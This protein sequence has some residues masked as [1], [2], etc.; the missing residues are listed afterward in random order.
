LTES[1]GPQLPRSL[2]LR[3]PLLRPL[4]PRESADECAARLGI[5]LE[6]AQ[7]FAASDVIDLH[8]DSF[9]WRRIFGYRLDTRHGQGLFSAR[10]YSQVDFPRLRQVGI[11]G[12]TWVITT[13]PLRTTRGRALALAKNL[14]AIEGEL[15][16][17]PSD[18]R[19]VSTY[20]EYRSA[21]DNGLHA[22]FVGI[23]GGNA[24]TPDFAPLEAL[25][26]RRLLR[27]TLTHLTS[28][29]LGETSAPLGSA[30]GLGARGPE[31]VHLLNQKRIFVDLAH[32]N[33]LGFFEA[34]EA[35]DTS[36]P[37]IVTHT[38]V[39]AVHKH[40]RNLDDEQIRAIADRG[41]TLGIMYHT[42]F[43]DRTWGRASLD[44]VCAHIEHV[45]A[46]V[47]D[48]FVSLG[49]D[50]DGAIVTPKD[51][52]TCLEL[53]RLIQALLDRRWSP[54]SIQKLLGGNFL[55]VLRE[56]RGSE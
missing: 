1:P 5:S 41:G 30:R 48:D 44:V 6:A 37:P 35:H 34:L 19:R 46:K 10:F 20:A 13:N 7:L 24:I 33:R 39:S 2:L 55:R 43:L 53:P 9:I 14:A 8:V 28:S 26:A 52:P 32:I 38:G 22:A 56:L 40:W 18:I 50:W 25:E 29:W 12:A 17:Y 23:Q 51:M 36:L 27:I 45:K 16:A 47:G 11:S 54:Q 31:L 3:P 4:W 21:R 15:D 49:S 42:P